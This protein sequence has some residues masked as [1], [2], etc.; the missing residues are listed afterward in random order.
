MMRL[1]KSQISRLQRLVAGERVAS[2]SLRKELA[3]ELLDE[4]LLTVCA[5]GSR[6]TYRAISPAALRDFLCS[7]YEE[8]RAFGTSDGLE[9]EGGAPSGVNSRAQQAAATGNSKIV[10]VRSC[11]GFP[12]NCYEPVCCSLG[13]KE[14]VINPSDGSFMFIADWRSFRIPSDVMVV[15]IENME[16]FIEIRRQRV[17]FEEYIARFFPEMREAPLL[18]VS[19][20]PQSEDLRAWLRN[21]PNR[22]IHF[23]DFDLAGISIFLNE[24]RKYLGDRASFLIPDDIGERLSVGSR[25]RY[26]IQYPRFKTLTAEIPELSEL[27]TMIHRYRRCY[28]QEGYIAL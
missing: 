26:D 19:R 22:Y 25:E 10:G 7:R 3:D 9:P 16:N 21:M 17:F 6:R 12:V 27:I 24:F 8:Y 14:I 1:S 11:P 15:G 2:S 28:D 18:F 5:N 13:G 4:R 20:Y 23:G